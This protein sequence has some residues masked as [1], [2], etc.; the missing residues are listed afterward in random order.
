MKMNQ[1]RRQFPIP[2]RCAIGAALSLSTL[3]VGSAFG[4]TAIKP[5][6]VS[7]TGAST[8]FPVD[9]I[10][11]GSGLS[12]PLNTGDELSAGVTHTWG[13]ATGSDNWVSTDPGGFPSDWFAASGTIPTFVFDLGSD[14]ALNAAHFWNYGGGSGV[15]GT[16]QGN[17]A[18]TVEIRYNTAGQGTAA[19]AGPV[20]NGTLAHGPTFGS[21]TGSVLPQLDVPFGSTVTARYIEVRLTDNWYVTPGDGSGVTEGGVPARG[22]DRV[23]LGEVRFSLSAPVVPAYVETVLAQSPLAYWRFNDG[24]TTPSVDTAANL[25]SG[26]TALTAAYA[27]AT[28]PVPGALAGSTGTAARTAAGGAVS[29]PQNALLNPAGAFTVEVWLRPAAANP[30]GTLTCAI[31]SVQVNS[32]RSGWLIY[33]SDTGWNFR[34]YNQNG[35]A[36]AVSITGGGAPVIG[37]WYHVVA[38]WDGSVGT[39]YVNGALAATS[40]ATTYVPNPDT[41][42]TIG[43]RSDAGFAWAGDADEP[44]F[45]TGALSATRIAAH[46]ANGTSAAP[47]PSY[48]QVVLADAPVGYWRL[49]EAAFVPPAAANSGSLGAAATGKY[50]GG[51]VDSTEAPR[52]PQLPGFESDNT[53]VNLDG[54]NDYVGTVSGLL[55]NRSTFTISGW[56]RRG[57]D[58]A[59]R[60]GIWGQNDLVEFG[61][62]NNDTL[63]VWTDNGL[64]ISPNS[65]PNGQWAH[66]AIVQDGSPGT[67]TMY[68]NGVPA[69]SRQSV[70]PATNAFG[71]NIGGGGVF[72]GAGNFFKG[73]IDE[74]AIFGKALPAEDISAQ[75]Y[76]TVPGV[77]PFL[78]RAPVGTNIF[79][80]DTIYLS[81]GAAGSGPLQYQWTFDFNPIPGATRSSLTITNASVDNS[82]EY[83]VDVSNGQGSFTTDLI[84]VNVAPAPKPIINTQ[85][86]SASRY[87]G[88]S[89]TFRV[90]ATGGSRLRYQWQRAGTDIPNATNATYTIANVQAA[91]A[92]TYHVVLSNSGGTTISDDVTLATLTP[93]AG[94]ETEVVSRRPVAYWRLGES[95]GPVAHDYWGGFDGTYTDVTLGAEGGL[96]NDA[97]T[98]AEFNGT[99]SYVGTSL[100]LNALKAFT[101]IGW[102]R[103]GGDQADRTGLWGQND[104]VEFGYINNNTL[105]VWTDNGLDISPNPIPNGEWAQVA[106][107]NDGSPGTITMYTNAESAGS[108]VS[109]LPGANDFKFNIGGGG[110][111]DGTGNFFNGR[112]DDLAVF[113]RALTQEEICRL[114]T[115]GSG[116]YSRPCCN[117]KPTFILAGTSTE[118][119]EDAGPITI[120]GWL[121][122]LSAGPGES[123]QTVTLTVTPES[124]ALFLVPPAISAN[125]TLTYT[126]KPNAHGSVTVTVQATD[127][128]PNG[129]CDAN[130]SDLASFTIVIRSVND[131]PTLAS[132]PAITVAAG[133]TANGQLVGADPDGATVSYTLVTVA[134]H[135]TV[136]LQ[137]NTGAFSYAPTAGYSGPDSFT[138]AALDA[139]GC[140]SDVVTVNVTVTGGGNHC[141]TAVSDIGPAVELFLCGAETV[142]IAGDYTQWRARTDEPQAKVILD[143]LD[144]TD[145]DG[146]SLT[147]TWFTVEENGAVVPLATGG[148][149]N[150]VLE[151]GMYTIRLVVDDGQCTDSMDVDIHIISPSE[152]IDAVIQDVKDGGLGSRNRRPLISLLKSASACFDRGLCDSGVRQLEAFIRKVRAQIE[153]EKPIV[154]EQLIGKAQ[155]ILDNVTCAP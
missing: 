23:G 61:Y 36:T 67:M 41:A 48:D 69:G 20:I 126:A 13:V 118:S 140:R 21:A 40:T 135:G 111:F 82:G 106:L 39:L 110:I 64:D 46:Y 107:V 89:V 117:D 2:R 85:P 119:D 128:G 147:Y 19:F 91:D 150:V 130:V 71:F 8:L 155:E 37:N 90:D 34:T 101:M 80:G 45:Y 146:N 88:A 47:S 153:P 78:V 93:A 7:L 145:V 42:F 76:S 12:A 3:L 122:E 28:H 35:T 56:I 33:Q 98:S 123:D 141:P 29:V 84:R 38:V 114:F 60:T 148:K 74:V 68:T 11:N 136:G 72:D 112:I 102:M 137:A 24:H 120:P 99:S 149:T 142:V 32:P 58:Q 10:I 125:G 50:F 105:E 52:P 43:T 27:G 5:V 116:R 151:P 63:E 26:G 109:T 14:Q 79:E 132:V 75:Y 70:L 143:G 4:A 103:R 30:A 92:G 51:A 96:I 17:A 121:S 104:L 94:Y 86:L 25:G 124:T 134:L 83:W 127:S 108:R 65:I 16:I 154:A 100:S 81:V 152:A 1:I 139:D 6:S 144:S 129:G 31:S 53:A 131:C 18:K 87:V 115:T 95:T 55:N 62:I 133:A 9:Q 15:A 22:G 54:I 77:A 59:A 44:A 66:L 57:A 97:N 138:V 49:N 113:D 73:Q